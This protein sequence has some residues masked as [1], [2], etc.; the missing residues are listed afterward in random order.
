[1][2]RITFTFWMSVILSMS[3]NWVA[4]TI[5][6]YG[7][8]DNHTSVI[9]VDINKQLFIDGRFIE[10]SK[11]IQ[12]TP[13]QPLKKEIVFRPDG[14]EKKGMFWIS[15]VL[16]VDDGYLMYYGTRPSRPSR[17]VKRKRPTAMHVAKSRDGIHWER[18]TVGLIDIGEGKQNNVVMVGAWGTVFLDPNE[19]DGY[20]FWVLGHLGRNPWW[21]ETEKV[22][23]DDSS[24]PP[25]KQKALRLC[26]SKDG[27]HWSCVKDPV[28]PFTGDTRNQGLY[29]PRIKKY[30]AYLRSR[31]GGHGS[32][33]VARGES[34]Q[35]LGQWP[36][37][38]DPDR[39][40]R[41]E[42]QEH[43]LMTELPLVMMADEQDPPKFGLYTPNVNIYPWAE[44]VYVAFPGYYRLRDGIPSFGRD[45][46]GKPANE[47]PLCPGLAV[48]RDGISWRRFRTSYVPLGQIGEI[49]GGTIYMGVGMIRQGDEIWQYTSASPHTHH[50]FGK[51]LPG[52]DGGILRLVQRLDG[53]VSAD[54]GPEGGHILTPPIV[55]KGNRLRLNVDCNAL[56]EVWVEIQDANGKPI[57]GYSMD[58]AVSVDLN[59]VAEEVW[60]QK[61]PDVGPLSGKPIR[62]HF[63]MRSTKLYA[64]Q[65]D[66]P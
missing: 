53:F 51:T 65:F 18:I 19:T 1:M 41:R 17:E 37:T 44:D 54:T 59:G 46:R 66:Y 63:R 57:P 52:M 29:D 39:D 33:A 11:G 20:R 10:S 7:A 35:L 42:G 6:A 26:R 49:D 28:F 16:K 47:G 27:I 62:L 36:F 34:E 61:G 21:P 60:W 64:F 32:R 55:F 58:Q 14:S 5:Y 48:S 15:S 25:I 31:P 3:T 9:N 40:Q 30:V 24:T 8:D 45:Q 56:G 12:L 4:I 50:G 2:V 43:W 22:L 23:P 13:N 38:P